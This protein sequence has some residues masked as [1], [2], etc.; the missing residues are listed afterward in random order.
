[1]SFLCPG[2]VHPSGLV[3]GKQG[4]LWWCLAPAF[5]SSPQGLPVSLTYLGIFQKCLS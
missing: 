1:M 3:M 2:P 4:P 5:P